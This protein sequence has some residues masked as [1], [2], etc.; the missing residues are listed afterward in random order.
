MSRKKELISNIGLRLDGR[1]AGE[2]RRIRCKLGVFSEPDGSAYIEQGLTKVLAAVY[3]PHQ[4]RGGRSKAQHDSAIVNC[5][6]SMAVFSTGE[7]K[8]RPRG[9]R[10]STEMSIH[11][12]QALVAAIKVELYPWTQIDV[13][14]EVL[15]A[16][17]GIYPACVN[18]AT[19]ALIDAGIPL[20]EYVCACTASLA[21]DDIPMIDISHQEEVMGGPT[22]TVAALP[23]SKKV[24]LLEMSQRFH[25]DHLPKVL[26]TALQGCVDIK[27]IL[28]VTVS[29]NVKEIGSSTRWGNM[30]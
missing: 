24:V 11:L 8:R 30:T 12:H 3:G 22:L 1:R 13:Y 28:D 2:L 4:V 16:D 18:A 9:D 17:G 21:N 27:N 7:R 23:M 10:K 5:Q 29:N 15:H 20:K 19:L 25:V 26:K 6:F 14:V